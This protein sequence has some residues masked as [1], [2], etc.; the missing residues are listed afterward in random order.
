MKPKNTIC[1]WFDK[2]AQEAARFYAITFPDRREFERNEWLP[3]INSNCDS[4]L[5]DAPSR[6][7]DL[8]QLCGPHC[9]VNP[10][11]IFHE[12]ACER[13]SRTIESPSLSCRLNAP[14]LRRAEAGHQ[15]ARTNI[16]KPR[17]VNRSNNAV[18]EP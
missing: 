11:L 1:L 10:R 6:R 5:R 16:P 7:H 18:S 17:S 8:P 15:R 9:R 12:L 2:D 14:Q 3:A 13:Y 4:R